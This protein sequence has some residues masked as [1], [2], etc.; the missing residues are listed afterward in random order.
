MSAR[1]PAGI[2]TTLPLMSALRWAIVLSV[3][4]EFSTV[5]SLQASPLEAVLSGARQRLTAA[6]FAFDPDVVR[7]EYDEQRQVF[8]ELYPIQQAR[9]T[10]SAD[11]AKLLTGW[12]GFSTEC[13]TGS[14][15]LYV[16]A[17]RAP[18][19]NFVNMWIDV[20]LRQLARAWNRDEAREYFG[21]LAAAAGGCNA[22]AGYGH[23]PL[24]FT[25]VAPT[26]T[27]DSIVSLPEFP[28]EPASV[29]LIRADD[30]DRLSAD[31]TFLTRVWA[32]FNGDLVTSGYWVF[33]NK[34]FGKMWG[35]HV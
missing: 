28:A 25:V 21:A 3:A 32:S 10:G 20:S 2:R 35:M 31:E 24:D 8:D 5:L 13:W 6:G 15:G 23:G 9:V 22:I 11:A 4:T 30:F 29:G 7:V 12:E 27:V 17:A 34:D 33:V 18:N 19:A 16:L 1:G 14:L 26:S